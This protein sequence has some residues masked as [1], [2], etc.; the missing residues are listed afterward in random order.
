M[1]IRLICVEDGLENVGF[2]KLAAYVKS[3]HQNTI[4][5]YV[6]TGNIYSLLHSLGFSLVM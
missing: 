3:I 4:A 1:E 5:A 6:P 2:K